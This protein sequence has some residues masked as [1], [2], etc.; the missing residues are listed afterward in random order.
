[1]E[2]ASVWI[3]DV[4]S[5]KGLAERVSSGLGY[6]WMTLSILFVYSSRGE[7]TSTFC[8]DCL[9]VVYEISAL[10]RSRGYRRGK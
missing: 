4:G 8:C 7:D 9:V 10:A 2:D 1:M 6:R 3:G 5:E